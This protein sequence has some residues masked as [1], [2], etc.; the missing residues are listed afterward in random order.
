MSGRHQQHVCVRGLP[1]AGVPL[2]DH[3]GLCGQGARQ[4]RGFSGEQEPAALADLETLHLTTL[5]VSVSLRVPFRSEY[6]AA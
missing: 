1:E 3:D 4:G 5:S 6:K 2:H